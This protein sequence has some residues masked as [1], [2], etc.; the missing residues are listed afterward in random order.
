MY[1]KDLWAYGS[2]FLTNKHSLN[3]ITHRGRSCS[4]GRGRSCGGALISPSSN[5]DSYLLS[6]VSPMKYMNI[7]K[8]I[9]AKTQRRGGALK[10]IR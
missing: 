6:L 4:G 3:Q 8:P 2:G 10:F 9:K 7:S 1:K 5:I